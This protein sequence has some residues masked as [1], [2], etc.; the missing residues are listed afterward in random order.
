MAGS[1]GAWAS[2]REAFG[3]DVIAH[4]VYRWPEDD[5]RAA[6]R[7]ELDELF[8]RADVDQPA[9]TADA[10]RPPAWSTAIG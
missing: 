4:D 8:A 6:S 1:A 9:F 7:C 10:R 3:M 5:G 2:W